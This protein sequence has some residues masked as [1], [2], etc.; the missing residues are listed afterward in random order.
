M[1]LGGLWHGAA[2]HFLVWGAYQ[3]LLL[4]LHK[5]YTHALEKLGVASKLMSSR[6]Y[7]VVSIVVTFH[8]VCLGW[9]I[10]RA[11]TTASM[12]Q[13]LQKLM[14]VP[15]ELLHFSASQLAVLQIRD[16]IIFPA[17]V[18]LLP[19][20]MISHVVVNW[21]NDKKIY[22]SPPWALQV[23]M[24]VAMMCLLTIFSPDTSPRFIY[25]QF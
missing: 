2:M 12:L 4:I 21:L 13:I 3:G 22:K 15:A 23:G 24:M 10:F 6:L 1:A 5:E 25:F 7:H 20:L 9:V 16:P 19:C 17:L 14:M 18:V 8:I 11:D